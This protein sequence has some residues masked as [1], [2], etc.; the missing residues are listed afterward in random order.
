MYLK[1]QR[2]ERIASFLIYFLVVVGIPGHPGPQGPNGPP[3]R[4]GLNGIPGAKGEKGAP[5]EPGRRGKKGSSG[6]PG[7]NGTDGTPGWRG[8]EGPRGMRGAIGPQGPTGAKGEPGEPGKQG[9]PGTERILR[10]CNCD[11]NSPTQVFY[12]NSG[13]WVSEKPMTGY[14]DVTSANGEFHVKV[15]APITY[16][17]HVGGKFGNHART[18]EVILLSFLTQASKQPA[19]QMV[20]FID[21]LSHK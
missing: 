21:F 5:G 4:N 7:L 19:K 6:E 8:K 13:Y 20:D 1:T 16:I 10:V 14:N 2:W 15:V 9:P 18:S 17:L 12:V 3:G 11:W